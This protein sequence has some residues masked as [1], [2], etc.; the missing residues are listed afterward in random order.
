MRP[1][2]LAI[3]GF[4]PYAKL[5]EIDFR[6]FGKG[7]LYLITGDT[8]A[9]KT[10]IFDAIAYA[11]YGSPSGNNRDTSMLRSKYADAS[12][13][14]FVE[15]TF[16]YRGKT[17]KVRRNPEYERAS[18]RGNGMT[19]QV[20]EAV[21]TYPDGKVVTKKNEVDLAVR[22]VLG[23]DR[24]Q[25]CQISMIAQGDFLKLLLASTKERM[26][27]FRNIFKTSFYSTLQERLKKDT[28]AIHDRREN[29]KQ[30]IQQYIDGVECGLN[31]SC[32]E[33]LCKAKENDMFIEDVI[34]LIQTIINKDT[35]EEENIANEKHKLQ[36]D[37]D[38]VKAHIMKGEEIN[39]DKKEL[40]D[41][42]TNLRQSNQEKMKLELV[43]A[44]IK[45]KQKEV[46]VYIK[47]IG[48]I[49]SSLQEYDETL[50]KKNVLSQNKR[51]I[52][53]LQNKI[54]EM[55][56]EMNTVSSL[57]DEYT[58]ELE[59]LQQVGENILKY[60]MDY[61]QQE[62]E[63]HQFHVLRSEIGSYTSIQKKYK[64]A[65]VRYEEVCCACLS[66]KKDYETKKRMYLDAQAGILADMLIEGVACPVCGSTSHP[67]LAQKPF[68]APN[69]E[70]LDRAQ[71][72]WEQSAEQENRA[73]ENASRY[74]GTLV[75][76]QKSLDKKI[77]ELF[78]K[79]IELNEVESY[80]SSKMKLVEL[81]RQ[82]TSHQIQKEK[83]KVSRKKEIEQELPI[84][85]EK[86]KQLEEEIKSLSK[87]QAALLAESAII[88]KN[89]HSLENK[90]E[91]DSKKQAMQEMNR[92]QRK[93][94]D[95]IKSGE[96]IQRQLTSNKERIASLQATK[97]QLKKRLQEVEEIDLE[98]ENIRLHVLQEQWN[99]NENKSKVIHSRILN[100]RKNLEHIE[101]NK[102]DLEQVEKQYSW[103]KSLS[104]TANGNV[105]G[106]D[107][108]MFETY[109]QMNYFDRILARANQRL[110]IMSNGQYDL[111]R[112]KE[113]LTRQGQTGLDLNVIDHYNGTERSVKS[114]S[115]G[116]SFKASLA[117][118]LG[119]ADEIQSSAG[120]IQLD[121][122]FVDEGFGSLDE[123][124][125]S[126]AMKALTSLASQNRLVGIISHVDALKQQIDQQIIVKKEA[127]GGSKVQIVV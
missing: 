91:F 96:D 8:G 61:K 62:E 17:Y 126:Q 40:L 88:E 59:S 81:D 121:T 22:D 49:Q 46:D 117:L 101:K 6:Q 94:D 77:I 25:F 84:K 119:L 56:K 87:E 80:I 90:L 38:I 12:T 125:L 42:E 11:L 18:K 74:K 9:G 120:G 76:K 75:E 103:M 32:N 113:S 41:I 97:N 104:N 48:S 39:S 82:N 19:K 72:R 122:M 66:F 44:S 30:S 20:A 14:T 15:L 110:M 2:Q 29:L 67:S 53:T 47:K 7:G 70:D 111:V 100:N 54:Q 43:G 4:G 51:N 78:H 65:I 34:H 24:N 36:A 3:S 86:K 28:S 21:F 127:S 109:I 85:N 115:G 33:D 45:E 31:D 124:S 98:Q 60:E 93:I 50:D 102:K 69:Q 23:I 73:R 68:N 52:E 63:L 58:N 27:I 108:I 64:E 26:E 71:H 79:E 116:E 106:K 1:I 55:K 5:T 107:K 89:I 95:I 35:K 99:Q 57:I 114:L 123:N 16:E 10:T 112:R 13:P 92:L 37:L 105:S 118:A 83:R